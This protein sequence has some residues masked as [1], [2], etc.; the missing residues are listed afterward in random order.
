MNLK[1]KHFL[2]YDLGLFTENASRLSRDYA[3]VKY[4]YPWVESFSEPF[5]LKIGEA[6]RAWNV[7]RPSGTRWTRPTLFSSAKSFCP[8]SNPASTRSAGCR[9]SAVLARYVHGQGREHVPAGHSSAYPG[10]DGAAIPPA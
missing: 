9:G 6:S 7:R 10:P 5:K 8:E 1:N 2:V 4:F 3:S